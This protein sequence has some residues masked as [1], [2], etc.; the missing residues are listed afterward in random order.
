M[1]KQMII[2]AI[3]LLAI[4]CKKE[5]RQ[6][7]A[8]TDQR[9]PL[10]S[11]SEAVVTTPANP[12]NPY[13]S[14]GRMHNAGLDYI[15][16]MILRTGDATA[17]AINRYISLF[18]RDSLH[19]VM[20]VISPAPHLLIRQGSPDELNKAI[21]QLPYSLSVKS[22]LNRLVDLA[23]D[24]TGTWNYAAFKKQ[25]MNLENK[26]LT[27]RALAIDQQRILLSAASVARYSAAYWSAKAAQKNRNGCWWC[28]PVSWAFVVVHDITGTVVTGG[29][30]GGIA[31]SKFSSGFVDVDWE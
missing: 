10:R 23:K 19:I 29:V 12:I 30:P 4:A 28:G 6:N 22:Y 16:R 1:K 18:C 13:D 11:L 20:P 24:S 17:G 15:S 26:V 21:G 2:I 3:A 31:F 27:D 9:S 8:S 5:T 7:N 14:V 25:V